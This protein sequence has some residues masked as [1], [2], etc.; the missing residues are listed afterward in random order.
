MRSTVNGMMPFIPTTAGKHPGEPTSALLP[1]LV[2]CL[3]CRVLQSPAL[4]HPSKS[5]A[6]CYTNRLAS[7]FLV[8]YP[9]GQD[10]GLPSL[11]FPESG[12]AWAPVCIRAAA[13]VI[14]SVGIIL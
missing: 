14:D 13:E 4:S 2:S 11:H 1:S 12:G 9:L 8:R 5:A 3:I 10:G 6:V 7:S